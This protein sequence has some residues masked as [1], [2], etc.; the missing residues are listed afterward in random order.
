M[1]ARV[2]DDFPHG[3]VVT[4]NG[5]TDLSEKWSRGPLVIA[6]HRMWCPF[7]QQAAIQ[8]SSAVPEL[9]RMGAAAVIVYREDPG[10]VANVCEVRHTTATC[11]SDANRALEKAVELKRFRWW[12]YAAFSPVRLIGAIRAGARV[13]SVGANVL[14]GRGTFVV[15]RAG[16]IVY[17]HLATTAADIPPIDD[18]IAA[19]RAAA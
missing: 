17:C 15:D 7:C 1:G 11:V 13:G 10:K 18:V 6:F 12:R 5:P 3:S 16:R 9:Q 8:L 2:G 14:Q 4:A 19:A